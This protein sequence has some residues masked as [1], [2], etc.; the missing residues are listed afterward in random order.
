MKN[1]LILL[2]K[3]IPFFYNRV[4]KILFRQDAEICGAEACVLY[5]YIYIY[6]FIYIYIYLSLGFRM[7]VIFHHALK[8]KNVKGTLIL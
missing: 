2:W 1:V 5:I 7:S 3:L 6:L 4:K 8:T